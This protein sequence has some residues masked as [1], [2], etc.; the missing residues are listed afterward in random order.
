[1]ATYAAHETAVQLVF[2]A[3]LFSWM[4]L[5]KEKWTFIVFILLFVCGVY[6][7]QDLRGKDIFDTSQSYTGEL[8][9]HTGTVIDGDSLRGFATLQDGT[10]V[11]A[12]FRLTSNEQ[13][14]H[15]ERLVSNSKFLVT[16]VFEEATP[17]SH[18]YSFNMT[19]YLR[20]NGAASLLKVESIS[21]VMEN[22]TWINRLLKRRDLFKTHIREH[23]PETLAAEAEALLI[24]EREN[25]DPEDRR[26][27]QTLGISHLFAI[28]GLHVGIASG[29]LYVLL[30]RLHIR[31]ETALVI[32]LL[33]LPLYAVIAG[34]A[35]SVWRAL[36]MVVIVT[37][38]KL[39][40]IK[41][42]LANIMLTSI[43]VFVLWDPYAMYQIGFQLSYGAT[44]GIIYSLNMLR[45][46]K[47]PVKAGFVITFISQVTL[48][49]L[50]LFHFYELSLSA[51][52]VNSLFVPLFTVFILPANFLL[53]FLTAV[54][55]PV[56]N[57][58]FYFY[59]PLREHIDQLMIAIASLPYQLWVPGKPGI[60][61]FVL[62][63]S[64]VYLFY[65]AVEREFR[66]WHLLILFVPAI[67]FTSLPYMD[68]RLKVTFLDVGQG[69]SAVIEMP[70]RQAVYLVDSGGVLRF[71]VETFKEKKRPYEI[72]R[73]VVAPYLRGRGI[74]SLDAMILS[75]PDADH[76]E[77]AE[78][79]FGMFSV[80]E[81][82]L[83]PGSTSNALMLELAPFTAEAKVVFP[84][85]GSNW[86][87]GETDFIYL[88]P[89]DAKYEGNNDSLV[90]LMKTGDY[91]ILFTGDLEAE[92]EKDLLDSYGGE[93]AGL[94]VLKV[95]HH[96]SKTSSSEE[97][98][99]ALA[100]E[101]SIFSTGKDNRYGHPSPEVVERFNKLELKTLNTAE[102]GTITLLYD[103]NGIQ[104]EKMR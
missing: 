28:S 71:D 58:V 84:A 72:G 68:P 4:Y 79:I 3:L 52:V 90:L 41:V 104:L 76:A 18:R 37:S 10:I 23:F 9:F 30:I 91:R 65:C 11:Y 73:Q 77:G 14:L 70:Y 32:L 89:S 92:G 13:K 69:D 19:H 81:L 42:P 62:L 99:T 103:E 63:M 53:L 33:V 78:E 8:I 55:P 100:P 61:A 24:G 64:S 12:R 82:H 49:P 5:K 56:A 87:D 57:F 15:M 39:M 102:N 1:M 67:L 16:G 36:S 75:H 27:H 101:L 25:M 35:P 98:L 88:S 22:K 96:G 34:G 48:Y 47:S 26:I 93:L 85:A 6:I 60:G 21:G 97:F 74:S 59:E 38:G 17:P 40:N 83:T 66:W 80:K 95:G 51:F 94:T 45:A 20:H 50:L 46:I 54:F 29:L 7:V 31:K 43:V 2:M 86:R 44:F